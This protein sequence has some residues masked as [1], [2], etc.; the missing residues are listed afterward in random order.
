MQ[1]Q[2]LVDK[3]TELEETVR[4]NR[5]G[6][7]NILAFTD[8]D[9]KSKLELIRQLTIPMSLSYTTSLNSIK[10]YVKDSK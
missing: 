6:I 1:L 7:A 4:V 5:I 3:L 2:L 9:E 10:D 8:I